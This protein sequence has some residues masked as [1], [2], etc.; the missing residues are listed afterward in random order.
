LARSVC[1]SNPV[2]VT[3]CESHPLRVLTR[4]IIVSMERFNRTNTKIVS[5]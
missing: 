5:K 2:P 4:L 3:A 1:G